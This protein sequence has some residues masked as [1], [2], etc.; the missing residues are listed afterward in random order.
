MVD[1]TEYEVLSFEELEDMKREHALLKNRIEATRRKFALESKLRDAAQS[2]N[3]L[4]STKDGKGATELG[5]D[6]APKSP[7]KTRRSLLG[8]RPSENTTL[9]KTD[10]EY[11]ASVKKCEDLAQELWRLE[12]RD[13]NVRRRILEHTAGV[14]QMT[15]KGLK[16]NV[17]RDELPRSPESMASY[18]HQSVPRFDG[19][20][21]FDDRS[22][23]RIPDYM[24]DSMAI[25]AGPQADLQAVD[26]AEKRLE[27][28]TDRIR[29]MMQGLESS[30]TVEEP[31]LLAPNSVNKPGA[32][33]PARIDQLE[34]SLD[35]LSNAQARNQR[36]IV[37]SE[38]QMG[39]I[40]ARLYDM[41]A[42]SNNGQTPAVPPPDRASR[43]L[44]SQLSFVGLTIGQLNQRLE[45]FV[46]QK[47]ILT[48][49]IQQQRE[50]NTK[51]DSERDAQITDLT[52]QLAKAKRSV[53]ASEQELQA[54]R[55]QVDLLMEQLDEARGQIALREE[56]RFMDDSKALQA[57]K[58][59]HKQVVERLGSDLETKQQQLA[60]VQTQLANS[61]NEFDIRAQQHEQQVR[62]LSD[63]KERAEIET[64]RCQSELTALE[65][66][67]VRAQTELTVVRAELD[68]AYGTRAQRAADVSSNPAI[69]REIDS[70]NDKI[71]GLLTQMETAKRE[72][73]QV[74]SGLDERN[75]SL[76]QELERLRSQPA[77]APDSTNLRS[78][79]AMLEQELR[80]TVDDY[81][82][83][84]KASIEFE[85]ERD[86]LE[87]IIEGLRDRC[88]SL[89]SQLSDERVRWMGMK[90]PGTALRDGGAVELTSTMVLKNEF[91]KMMRDTRNENLKALRVCH[92]SPNSPLNLTLIFR[93]RLSKKS[94]AVW[95]LYSEI[96]EKTSNNNHHH[97]N[98][99]LANWVLYNKEIMTTYVFN[100]T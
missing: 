75:L 47:A 69:Q 30:A 92:Y 39:E 41:L 43:N 76:I 93:T 19:M 77:A 59:M 40:N 79:V 88:D 70:L 7:T 51:S 44:R 78:K 81:E 10:D 63:A 35:A 60:G 90:S 8:R 65:G 87:V 83:M 50:L 84:T 4:Y 42:F 82:L 6:G 17:R 12:Q 95:K 31:A 58:D 56:Q 1:S 23:Y 71:A 67:V 85:Q 13:Q 74:R 80:E 62:E 27:Q 73:E 86:Q 2:L 26:A 33:L 96:C 15:H 3:R 29:E 49:Q 37:D 98:P 68:G 52:E 24:R 91:K 66:E 38:G 25:G 21:E 14:L 28:V 89:E 64:T 72:H 9:T 16:K 20:D 61:R 11:A 48:T 97:T 22:L 32:Q 55:D 54:T 5:P 99:T 100:G 45:H 57:E 94:V 46:E 53:S 18:G 34:R 36:T